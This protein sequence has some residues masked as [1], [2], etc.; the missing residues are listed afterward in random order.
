MGQLT[1][2]KDWEVRKPEA[3]E[4]RGVMFEDIFQKF[5]KKTS[6]KSCFEIGCVPGTYLAYICK[7]F[8]YSAEGIDYLENT[9]E[10][11]GET[12]NKAGIKDYNI[13]EGDFTQ[14]QIPGQY[15]LVCS[16]GFIEHFSGDTEKEVAAKHVRLLK[17]GGLLMMDVPNFRYGQY[18]IHMLLDKK[19]LIEHNCRTMSLSYFR[20]LAE[21]HNLE[22]LYL[23]YYGG[24]FSFWTENK[25]PDFLQI[26]V[27]YFF[28]VI[29]HTVAFIARAFRFKNLDN[30]WFSPF[31]IFI[32]R[33]P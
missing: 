14:W 5:L 18:L 21:T 17:P 16:F 19:N 13:Y 23:S 9:A 26:A 24:P 12:L 4:A 29:Q 8:G 33:K 27:F 11:T 2:R 7:N 3:G 1:T 15:D 10:I 20:H 28:K 31:I 6:D 30:R 22:V 25:N 32:A